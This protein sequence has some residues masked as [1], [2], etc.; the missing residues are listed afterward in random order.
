MHSTVE[1]KFSIM[2]LGAVCVMDTLIYM[3]LL[4]CVGHWDSGVYCSFYVTIG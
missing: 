3:L 4:W 2:G 1:W